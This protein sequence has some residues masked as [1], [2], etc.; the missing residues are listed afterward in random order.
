MKKIFIVAFFA[1]NYYCAAQDTTSFCQLTGIPKAFGSELS[2]YVYPKD[3]TIGTKP[4]PCT[5]MVDGLNYMAAKG[6]VYVH[7]YSNITNGQ[8]SYVYV[9]KKVNKQLKK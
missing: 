2:I 1:I 3:E 6:W 8:T 4:I 7:Y 9:L 5:T